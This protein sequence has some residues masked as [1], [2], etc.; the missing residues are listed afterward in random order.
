MQKARKSKNSM[1]EQNGGLTLPDIKI[2]FTVT[3]IKRVWHQR[4]DR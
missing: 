1:E 3:V 4:K 2:Q